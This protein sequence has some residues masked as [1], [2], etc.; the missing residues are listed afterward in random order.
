MGGSPCYG[1]GLPWEL[2]GKEDLL[3]VFTKGMVSCAILVCTVQI[4]TVPTGGHAVVP[5]PA[6]ALLAQWQLVAWL[7]MCALVVFLCCASNYPHPPL[8]PASPHP[9]CCPSLGSLQQHLFQDVNIT[10]RNGCVP[11]TTASYMVRQGPKRECRGCSSSAVTVTSIS[12]HSY[13]MLPLA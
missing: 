8:D 2:V 13:R 7:A 12:H 4:V 1:A 11:A 10:Q 3:S 6:T 5:K 9:T